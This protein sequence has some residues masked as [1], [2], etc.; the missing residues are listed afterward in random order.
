MPLYQCTE[1][2]H[3]KKLLS[4]IASWMACVKVHIPTDM[5]D[6]LWFDKSQSSSNPQVEKEDNQQQEEYIVTVTKSLSLSKK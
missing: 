6:L 3:S 1:E 4:R 2:K 5:F